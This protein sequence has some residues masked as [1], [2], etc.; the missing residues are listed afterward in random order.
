MLAKVGLHACPFLL[1]S[2]L[3]GCNLPDKDNTARD[4]EPQFTIH[5]SVEQNTILVVLQAP[6][7]R[8]RGVVLVTYI[9]TDDS[10]REWVIE[11][12]LP[13]GGMVEK[14]PPIEYG[15]NRT[16]ACRIEVFRDTP[17]SPLMRSVYAAIIEHERAAP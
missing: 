1:A 15:R 16:R 13:P 4:T 2:L 11:F 14:R 8:V 10:D 3:S 9:L 6:S 5:A 17:D 7:Q 12:D